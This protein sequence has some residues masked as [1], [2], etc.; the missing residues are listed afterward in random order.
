MPDRVTEA[1]FVSAEPP[2]TVGLDVLIEYLTEYLAFLHNAGN[3]VLYSLPNYD[4]RLAINYSLMHD[5]D[6]TVLEVNDIPGVSVDK[7]N[8]YLASIW[9]KAAMMRIGGDATDWKLLCPA[10]YR[11]SWHPMP[12]TGDHFRLH[13]GAPRVTLLC[14]REAIIS[15][16]VDEALFYEDTDLT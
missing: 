4:D 7:I 16:N 12:E 9:F 13:L 3:H 2:V 1:K 11:T 6:S 10:E 14:S 15:F 5:S 8:A